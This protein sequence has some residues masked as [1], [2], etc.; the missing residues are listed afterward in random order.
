MRQSV[1]PGYTA[2]ASLG[3]QH[4]THRSASRYGL[5]TV[6]SRIIPQRARLLGSG[7]A[8]GWY[9]ELWADFEDGITWLE[10]EGDY[11]YFGR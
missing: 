8:D 1:L 5:V 2:E 4:R 7:F 10:C 3:D 9:C 6:S 11:T